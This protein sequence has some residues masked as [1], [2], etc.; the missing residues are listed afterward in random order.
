[1]RSYR[2]ASVQDLINQTL[3]SI[4]RVGS[5]DDH[6]EQ[7]VFTTD[8]GRI[9]KL[10]PNQDCCENFYIES[11][12]GDLGNLLGLPIVR[13]K[14]DS[15]WGEPPLNESSPTCVWSLYRFSTLKASVTIRWCS[16]SDG[17][18]S[19]SVS[20]CEVTKEA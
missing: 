12:M 11:I 16:S 18:Y 13:A 2:H 19:E 20:F 5:V 17:Y 14:E 8:K 6:S 1:M 15:E 4:E 3:I 9:Y 10:C 7:I